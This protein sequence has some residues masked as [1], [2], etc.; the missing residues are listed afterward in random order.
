MMLTRRN[1][2][3]AWSQVIFI[4][5]NQKRTYNPPEAYNSIPMLGF[6]KEPIKIYFLIIMELSCISEL[7]IKSL[8]VTYKTFVLRAVKGNDEVCIVQSN[9]TKAINLWYSK[10]SLSFSYSFFREIVRKLCSLPAKTVLQSKRRLGQP[11]TP[12]QDSKQIVVARNRASCAATACAENNKVPYPFS[13]TRKADWAIPKKSTPPW[14]KACW[15]ISRKVGVNGC[16]NPDGR[17]A[18]SLKIHPQGLLSISFMFQQLQ[19]ATKWVE[20]LR[21]KLGFFTFY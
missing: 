19:S 6:Y 7:Q 20:T 3:R 9:S 11:L 21:P 15:E 8:R 1:E 5:V 12:R 2:N 13:I 14:Q 10:K 18:L 4:D 16:E 17:G